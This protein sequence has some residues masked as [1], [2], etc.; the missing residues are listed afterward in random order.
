MARVRYISLKEPIRCKF[1]G[2]KC[3]SFVTDVAHSLYQRL[4][5][6]PLLPKCLVDLADKLYESITLL[7]FFVLKLYYLAT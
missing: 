7:L 1:M 3:F 4:G 5:N 6:S 2:T